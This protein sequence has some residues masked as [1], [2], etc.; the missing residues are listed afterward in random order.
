L[1]DIA[2]QCQFRAARGVEALPI[3]QKVVE[4]LSF[5]LNAESA[6]QVTTELISKE[7]FKTEP[8]L[9][10]KFLVAVAKKVALDSA[11]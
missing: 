4:S 2:G 11:V 3:V 1:A 10:A 7:W 5:E 9:V 6:R 8:A